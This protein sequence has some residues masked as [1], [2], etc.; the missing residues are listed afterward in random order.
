MR[1]SRR[2]LLRRLLTHGECSIPVQAKEAAHLE[3]IEVLRWTAVPPQ[4]EKGTLGLG[5]V[6][7]AN[8]ITLSV[9]SDKGPAPFPLPCP[10]YVD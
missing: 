3:G 6:S 10:A 5:L 4:G 1:L 7:Y 9:V 2:S 8:H